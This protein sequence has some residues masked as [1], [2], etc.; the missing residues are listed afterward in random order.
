MKRLPSEKPD[1][2]RDW[3]TRPDPFAEVWPEVAEQLA[4]APGLRAKTLWGWLQQRYSGRFSEGQLRTLQRRIKDWRA[5]QG[6]G[7]EVYFSQV[8][9]P[10]RLCA[11]D[12]THMDSLNI[13]IG[14]QRF[15]HLVYHFVLTYSNWESVTICFSESFES[16]SVGLQNAV[17]DLGGVPQRHR[18]DR[19][20]AAVNNLS[21]RREFTERY[22]ALLGHYRLVGEKIQAR[23]AHENGDAESSHRHFKDAVEQ[24]LLLRGSRDF[25]S[26]PEYESFLEEVRRQRNAGRSPRFAEE[27]ALLEPLP[28]RRLESCKRLEVTVSSGSVI[29]VQNNVYSV[30]SRLMGERVEV[31]IYLEHVEVW[32]GQKLVE[33]LPRLRGRGKQ[34]IDY[35]HV[36]D[37]LVRK[38]GAL[39]NYRY[40]EELFPSSQFRLAY[41]L[42]HESM[43][44]RA[45]R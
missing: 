8:H 27:Q 17:W 25:A 2:P 35:R 21:E 15:D 44:T 37:T 11:S 14:G 1:Q 18:S 9:H 22:Q 26:R 45:D 34:R 29:H 40:R 6:P 41:D 30:N 7:Q 36:I 13:T 23:Q 4:L 3:R 20:S 16:L 10:G 42:L 43:P 5:T 19:M 24:A 39:A 12:F 38:P 33:T 32:Y 28:S 31:R